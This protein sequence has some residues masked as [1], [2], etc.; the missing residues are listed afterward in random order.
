[1][2]QTWEC[3]DHVRGNSNSCQKLEETRKGFLREIKSDHGSCRRHD[4]KKFGL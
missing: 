4:L 3:C 1:M 2:G